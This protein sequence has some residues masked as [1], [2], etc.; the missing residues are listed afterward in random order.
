[1]APTWSFQCG[2]PPSGAT[3][4]YVVPPRP[5]VVSQKP[6]RDTF[7]GPYVVFPMPSTWCPLGAYVVFP[8]PLGP[9]WCPQS[10]YVAPTWCPL[11]PY[12]VLSH[13][14]G[15]RCG[16][17]T[18]FFPWPLRGAALALRGVPKTLTGYFPMA[19]MLVS[20]WSFPWP[21]RRTPKTLTWYFPTAPVQEP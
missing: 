12:V 17:Y 15:V 1:M 9:A 5:C 18:W 2:V 8:M 6:L 14:P 4:P 10:L 19:P 21:L 3:G 13:G 20:P 16:P 7:S 11:T